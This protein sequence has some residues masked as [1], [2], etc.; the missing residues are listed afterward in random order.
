MSKAKP[1]KLPAQKS[2]LMAAYAQGMR[3]NLTPSEKLLWQAIS[4]T[5]AWSGL[6][7]PGPRGAIYRRFLGPQNQ[8]HH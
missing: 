6:S 5:A 7:A 3:Q 4:A 2:S 1:P 8:A